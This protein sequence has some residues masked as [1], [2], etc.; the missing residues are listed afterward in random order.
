MNRDKPTDIAIVSGR[1]YEVDSE[2]TSVV[3]ITLNEH[4]NNVLSKELIEKLITLPAPEPGFRWAEIREEIP[5]GP[6]RVYSVA[7]ANYLSDVNP[8]KSCYVGRKNP[9]GNNLF[10]QVPLVLRYGDPGFEEWLRTFTSPDQPP[11]GYR[12]EQR[13]SIPNKRGWIAYHCDNSRWGVTYQSSIGDSPYGHKE[14]NLAAYAV[15]EDWPVAREKSNIPKC[16]I[17]GEEIRQFYISYVCGKAYHDLCID[18]MASE[19][20]VAREENDRLNRHYK[21]LHHDYEKAAKGRDKWKAHAERLAE[22]YK[23]LQEFIHESHGIYGWH[24][25]G[26]ILGWYE[27]ESVSE[28]EQLLLDHE[29]MM[30]G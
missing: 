7:T 2:S 18:K 14:D 24:Q 21:T 4:C 17:C 9:I 6:Y 3:S 27:I 20:T 22:A 19:L 29:Q 25:N 1:P 16:A 8:K 11:P 28:L 15:P 26:A 30:K 12:L 5:R 13:D 23:D 10:Y